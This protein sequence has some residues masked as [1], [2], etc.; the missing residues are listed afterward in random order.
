MVTFLLIL[1]AAVP[2]IGSA[3]MTIYWSPAKRIPDYDDQYNPPIMVA[4]QYQ[5]IHAFN[6]QPINGSQNAIFYR[7]FAR[8]QGWSIPIDIIYPVTTEANVVQ[9]AYFDQVGYIHLIYYQGVAP[10]AAIYYTRAPLINADKVS[11]WLK[12]VII[13]KDAGPATYAALS[14]D[15]N[16]NLVVI[17]SGMSDGVGVYEV[18]SLNGGDTWSEPEAVY[19]VTDSTL[20]PVNIKIDFDSSGN[21]H[22]VWANTDH[23]GNGVEVYYL[24]IRAGFQDW[25]EPV[26]LAARDEG[27]YSTRWPTIKVYN[28][29]LIVVYQDGSPASRWTRRSRDWGTTWTSPQRVSSHEGEYGYAVMQIDSSGYLHMILGN[30]T[31]TIPLLHGMWHTVWLNNRWSEPEP[32]FVGPPTNRF[33]PTE[34]VAVISQGNLLLA[35]WHNDVAPEYRSGP[36]FSFSVL[37]TPELPSM[38][39]PTIIPSPTLVQFNTQATSVHLPTSTFPPLLPNKDNELEIPVVVANPALPIFLGIVPVICLILVIYIV[40][41]KNH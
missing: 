40:K 36:W 33:D 28:D 6:S 41:R 11:E 15:K 16:G 27:D 14:G 26:L 3:Q 30:R 7:K 10:Q 22:I 31:T 38:P 12:P 4:D 13:G 32:I 8:D 37:N 5:T 25:S 35:S 17:Y 20:S 9:D 2:D 39:L 1:V 29:E 23:S 19:R 21:V 18:H 34:P 24:Q